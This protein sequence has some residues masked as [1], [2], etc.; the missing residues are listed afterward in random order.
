MVGAMVNNLEHSG[1]L[2][3]KISSKVDQTQAYSVVIILDLIVITLIGV[4]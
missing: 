4:A 3:M 2:Y 1:D